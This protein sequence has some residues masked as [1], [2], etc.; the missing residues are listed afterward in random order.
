[1]ISVDNLDAADAPEHRLAE[2]L[3]QHAPFAANDGAP[4]RV[5]QPRS[6]RRLIRHDVIDECYG[7]LKIVN[8]RIAA[9]FFGH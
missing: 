6:F 7:I 9:V 3:L 4:A 5:A 8:N 2:D 1:V